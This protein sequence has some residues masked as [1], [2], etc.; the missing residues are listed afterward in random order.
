[1]EYEREYVHEGFLIDER[2]KEIIR[3]TV[4]KASSSGIAS[5]CIYVRRRDDVGDGDFRIL[6]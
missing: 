4:T 6:L 3:V 1:M 5:S 2:R